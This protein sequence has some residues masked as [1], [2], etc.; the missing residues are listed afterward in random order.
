MNSDS[1]LNLFDILQNN[2]LGAVALHSF[3]L[4]YTRVKIGKKDKIVEPSIDFLFY[5]LPIVYG[6][7]SLNSFKS[8]Y[9]LYTAITKDKSLSLGL[10]ERAEKMKK[11]TLDSL[12]LGFSKKLFTLNIEEYTIGLDKNYN[13]SSILKSMKFSNSFYNDVYKAS[14]RLGNIF[15]KKDT[16]MLQLKL[17]IRF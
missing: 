5:V 4:G 14:Y 12:N 13:N 10:Q 6:E 9:E 3:I 16:K 2:A 17:N 11:Q 8:S 1:D 15:A 7:S